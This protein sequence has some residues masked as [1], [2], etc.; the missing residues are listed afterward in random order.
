M[1]NLRAYQ[2]AVK[3]YRTSKIIPLNQ[4]EKDQFQRAALSIVLNL[5]EGTGKRTLKDQKKFYQ[6][7]FGS[8]RE[9]QALID[10]NPELFTNEQ[11]DLMDHTAAAVFKL[12]N[13][14]P[15]N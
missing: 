12:L 6:I 13:W 1:I 7:A 15:K 9:V 11:A 5:A 4:I 14:Q 10:L 2:L 8:I 3:F